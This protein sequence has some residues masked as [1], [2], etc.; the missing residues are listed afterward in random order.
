LG[1]GSAGK[2]RFEEKNKP[3]TQKELEEYW[4]YLELRDRVC[5]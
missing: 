3:M 5:P 4:S 1:S 2:T